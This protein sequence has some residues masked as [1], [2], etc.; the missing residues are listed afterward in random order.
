VSLLFL[1]TT[2]LTVVELILVVVVTVVGVLTSFCSVADLD[3][4]EPRYVCFRTQVLFQSVK[5]RL[6][7]VSRFIFRRLVSRAH[8]VYPRIPALTVYLLLLRTT[9]TQQQ[10]QHNVLLVSVSSQYNIL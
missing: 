8:I 7:S 10:H 6:A 3:G 4:C 9:A 2:S 5:S 1:S